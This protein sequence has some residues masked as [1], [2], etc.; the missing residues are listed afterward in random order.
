MRRALEYSK[1][2][3]VPIIDHCEDLELV[4]GGV[5]NEGV[6]STALG[7]R[8]WPGTAE[9]LV[10]QRDLLL[11]ED[12]GGHA[13]VA[14][15]STARS[16]AAVRRAK[17]RGVRATCEVTPHHLLLTDEAVR[18]YDTAAKMNPPLR[19]E[20]DRQAL[21]AALADGTI[22]AIVTDHAPHHVD[23]KCVEF[24]RAP[25]G[26]VGLE[27][28]VSLCIDRLVHGGVID[29]T[30]L[31]ELFTVG[32]ARVLRLDSGR[33]GVGRVADLTV[34]DLERRVT[35]DPSRFASKSRNSPF[36]GWTLRGAAVTTIV[37]G[38]VVHELAR[39]A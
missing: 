18:D 27:T 4:D 37:A 31:I 32:P 39:E 35:V 38:R 9:D 10:V 30:R 8:G 1:I 13:H 12:T 16:A 26:I 34:L 15:M 33:V 11:A 25:F 36:L 23:E 28:A 19:G 6:I 5:M 3:D 14:H 2:F 20:E 24:S 21:L 22:D 29:L 7:L 17:E